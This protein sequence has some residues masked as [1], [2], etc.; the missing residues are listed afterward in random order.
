MGV[1]P[2]TGLNPQ[3]PRK[4]LLLPSQLSHQEL[5]IKAESKGLVCAVESEG[6]GGDVRRRLTLG[7]SLGS[8]LHIL[9]IM[10]SF[11]SPTTLEGL[12]VC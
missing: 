1:C 8:V 3:P 12:W 5:G 9:V 7:W 2:E 4:W 10:A 6:G 11:T